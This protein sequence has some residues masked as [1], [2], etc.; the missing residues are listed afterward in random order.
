MIA[1]L[2]GGPACMEML[3]GLGH[4]PQRERPEE[5]ARRVAAFLAST[6]TP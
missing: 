5:I 4:V 1:R 3:A 6:G 2:A